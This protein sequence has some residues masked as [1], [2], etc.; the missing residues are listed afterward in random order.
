MTRMTPRIVLLLGST[1]AACGGTEPETRHVSV[2]GTLTYTGQAP[3]LSSAVLVLGV[4]EKS[5]PVSTA[6][7]AIDGPFAISGQVDAA[8]CASVYV[9]AS[10]QDG[11][12]GQIL[13]EVT[14]PLGA[15]GTH[16]VDLVVA[17]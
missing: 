1:L 8:D 11:V 4:T 10:V 3:P 16:V 12:T 17:P 7:S 9:A 6:L 2:S 15:C 5:A 13:G 14:E